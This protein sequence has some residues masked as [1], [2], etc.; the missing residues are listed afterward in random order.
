LRVALIHNPTSG[1]ASHDADG[2][3]AALARQG[4]EVEYRSTH[5]P[6]WSLVLAARPDL[7]V[8][9][10]GDGT[11][12]RVFKKLAGS[13]SP[14]ALIPVGSANNIARTLGLTSSD[15][16]ELVRTLPQF[17]QVPFDI[18]EVVTSQ[19]R[20]RFVESAGGGVFADVLDRADDETNGEDKVNHGLR[21][22][23]DS[24]VEQRASRWELELDGRELGR[25]LL[26]AEA[27]NIRHT[28]P[29]IPLTPFA[30]PGD[31]LLDVVLIA[32]GDREALA[33]YVKARLAGREARRPRFV[34]HRG[35]EL[36]AR[37][38][39]GRLLRVDDEAWA[40]DANADDSPVVVRAA[41]T[42]V[43]VLAPAPSASGSHDR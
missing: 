43:R 39:A 3:L 30:D 28:G 29:G 12:A 24:I 40:S 15:P 6:D 10:G 19:R 4:H 22:L 17:V 14:V 33:G 38:P 7:V 16:E 25:E 2:L 21:V 42:Q 36:V 35:R 41:V 13:S 5:D 31:G 9:A 11:I 26:G 8:A 1:D 23:G 18:G 27:T 37:P 20:E 34:V 32:P